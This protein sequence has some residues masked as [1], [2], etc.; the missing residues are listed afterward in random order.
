MNSIVNIVIIFIAVILVLIIIL[1]L[2]KRGGR[3]LTLHS[4]VEYMKSIGHLSVFKAYTKEIVTEIDHTWGD[5]GRKYLNW[6]ISEKKMAMIFEFEIDFRYDL[7]SADFSINRGEG[8]VYL[9][10]MPSC[11]YELHINSI[12]F[13]DEQGARL[14]PWL[15]PDLISKYGAGRFSES[16]KNRMVNAAIENSRNKAIRLIGNIEKDVQNSAISTLKA[17]CSSFG[18]NDPQFKFS[19]INESNLKLMSSA[20]DIAK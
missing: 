1:L 5:F 19:T 6:L 18:V 3:K 12:S 10:N 14:L 11:I 4:S 8:G 20:E 2:K 9:I 17:L 7:K 13:Y 16:D 15:L